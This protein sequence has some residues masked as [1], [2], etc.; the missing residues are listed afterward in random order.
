MM[1][2]MMHQPTDWLQGWVQD[3]MLSLL[4][5]ARMQWTKR[6]CALPLNLQYP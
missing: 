3:G 2:L 4:R 5:F 6:L 1:L